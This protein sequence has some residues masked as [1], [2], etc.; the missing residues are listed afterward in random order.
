MDAHQNR[1]THAEP[2]AGAG[3]GTPSGGLLDLPSAPAL[4][5]GA[6]ALDADDPQDDCDPG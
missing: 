5:K 3:D 1:V 2:G 4:T 6:A